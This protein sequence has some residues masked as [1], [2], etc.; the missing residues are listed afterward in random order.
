MLRLLILFFFLAL[1]HHVYSVQVQVVC[2][3][4]KLHLKDGTE[5]HSL[6]LKEPVTTL[7]V[8]QANCIRIELTHFLAILAL[9]QNAD[10]SRVTNEIH[11]FAKQANPEQ[12]YKL[13]GFIDKGGSDGLVR[14]SKAMQGSTETNLVLMDGLAYTV[15]VV[16][17]LCYIIVILSIK[18]VVFFRG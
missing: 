11:V 10:K 8:V 3:N 2:Q 16:T 12:W 6:A 13:D 18:F 14:F 17:L 9:V 15:A 1:Q 5:D 7:A 4:I